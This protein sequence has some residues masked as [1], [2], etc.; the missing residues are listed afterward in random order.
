MYER[1][2]N[3]SFCARC[4]KALD[5][6]TR[7]CPGCGTPVPTLQE[8]GPMTGQDF[9]NLGG[10][11]SVNPTY[12]QA[13]PYPQNMYGN[14]YAPQT[15]RESETKINAGVVIAALAIFLLI[16]IGC[17]ALAVHAFNKVKDGIKDLGETPSIE[18]TAECV[19]SE[20][21]DIS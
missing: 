5:P 18:M 2:S 6:D 19:P 1:G 14:P 12:G 21:A 4:G 11:Q 7:F 10:N 17:I 9:G 20:E 8:F 15:P 13:S 16:V 3:M